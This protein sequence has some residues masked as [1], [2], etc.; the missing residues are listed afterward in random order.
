MKQTKEDIKSIIGEAFH[1]AFRK[2]CISE[3]ASE[4]HKLI[5]KLPE[6]EWDSI[7]EWVYEGIEDELR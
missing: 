2:A 5:T 1:T 3:Q 7:L 4:I 6:D